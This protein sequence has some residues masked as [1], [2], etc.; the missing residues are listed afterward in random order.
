MR[1]IAD[2]IMVLGEK[3]GGVRRQ[4]RALGAAWFV[5]QRKDFALISKAFGE[6][7][8]QMI[9]RL[10]GK[11]TVVAFFLARQQHMQ[12]V[13]EVITP[14]RIVKSCATSLAF[15]QMGLIGFVLEH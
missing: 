6:T 8:G 11:G 10:V 14:L 4:M 9:E 15:Q 1:A 2:L 3:D 13:V 5:M 12:G 7:A